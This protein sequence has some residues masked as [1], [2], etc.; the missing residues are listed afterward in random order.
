MQPR[1]STTHAIVKE[2]RANH[3]IKNL[4]IFAPLFFAVEFFSVQNVYHTALLFFAFS[5]L[6]SSIYIINDIADYEKDRHHPKKKFR[7]IAAGQI[8]IRQG[9]WIAF[10]L[11]LIVIALATQLNARVDIILFLYF[12]MNISYSFFLKH[13]P[14]IEIFFVAFMYLLRVK[15]GGELLNIYIS[16]W[17][18]LVT[19]FLALFLIIGKRRAEFK[20]VAGSEHQTRV[21]LNKYTD[22]FLDH[23]LTV[24]ITGVILS[25]SLYTVEVDKPYMIY[26]SFFVFFGM[27]R[28]LYIIHQF[29]QGEAPE[30]MLFHDRWLLCTVLTWMVWMTGVFY[31]YG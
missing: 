8:S 17:L 11:L 14:V 24:V 1:Q 3:W 19:F 5:F 20:A 30:K 26:S 27:F 29:E 6:A 13:I 22:S 25:Y 7:P 16:P 21:V 31:L 9:Q 2:M 18:I 28:Y 4:L 15:A 12:C 10:L 23:I